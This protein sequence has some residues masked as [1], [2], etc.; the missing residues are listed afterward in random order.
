[1]KKRRWI[2]LLS[3][4]FQNAYFQGFINRSVFTGASKAVC[5]PGLNCYSCPG[6]LFACPLGA[7][8]TAMGSKAGPVIAYVAG[9]ITLFGLLMGRL[10]CGF[11]CPF[12][13]FQD[14]LYKIPVK[15]RTLP[16]RVD[17]PL[18]FVKYALLLLLVLALPPLLPGNFGI[19]VPYFCKLVCP[20]GTLE[21]GLPLT[22][23]D[24]NLRSMAGLLFVWKCTVLLAVLILSALLFRPFCKYLCPLGALYGL[25][26]NIGFYRMHIDADKCIHC[27]AC[28]NAC[29]MQVQVLTNPNHRECIRCGACKSA[30][31]SGAISARYGVC[32]GRDKQR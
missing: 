26:N 6:A 21:G 13:F 20:A 30:C 10:V 5:V 8:Q 15:K 18:R 28:E 12:G 27:N 31:P 24:P 1:M 22:L 25:F 23:T 32:R 17:R 7:L 9:L 3:T 19:S 14:L 16:K 11:V 4:L 29:P 2:Q